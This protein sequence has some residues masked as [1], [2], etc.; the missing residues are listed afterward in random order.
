MVWRPGPR[1]RAGELTMRPKLVEPDSLASER[2]DVQ[3]SS[4]LGCTNRK[5]LR[6]GTN[7]EGGPAVCEA[8]AGSR[9]DKKPRHPCSGVERF[10]GAVS[11]FAGNQ[12]IHVCT[13]RGFLSRMRPGRPVRDGRATPKALPGS[14][15]CTRSATPCRNSDGYRYEPGG[16]GAKKWNR[17]DSRKTEWAPEEVSTLSPVERSAFRFP[18]E[19][20][21]SRTRGRSS[22]P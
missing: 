8:P 11:W 10:A 18:R 6:A 20:G 3:D 22:D 16:H 19:S 5:Q 17:T 9:S 13:W 4:R 1:V 14:R 21:G 12:T 15:K 7:E 2:W